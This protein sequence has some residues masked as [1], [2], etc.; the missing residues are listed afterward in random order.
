MRYWYLLPMTLILLTACSRETAFEHFS[1]LD[2]RHERAVANL[3][4]V[5]LKE[6][7]RTTALLNIIYLNAVD[8]KLYHRQHYFFVAQ[9]DS[10]RLPLEEYAI[11]LNGKAPA[12]IVPLDDNCSLRKL[13]PLNNSWNAYYELVFKASE[14]ENLTLRFESDPSLQG[15][16]TY[17]TDR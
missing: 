6:D 10:R 11:T 17:H 12:G 2:S 4:R 9:Y 3:M 8:P 16:V 14:D 5:T 7:N 1:R 15:E 13:M